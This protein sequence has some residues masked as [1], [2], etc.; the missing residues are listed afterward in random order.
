MKKKH[1]R[2]EH[3]GPVHSSGQMQIIFSSAVPPLSQT[4]GVGARVDA[5]APIVGVD[6]EI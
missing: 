1:L 4:K 2:S 3:V 5:V 6:V